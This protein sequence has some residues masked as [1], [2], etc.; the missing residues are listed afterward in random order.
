MR[1]LLIFFAGSTVGSVVTTVAIT[2]CMMAK[3]GD[4]QLVDGQ[5]QWRE[6][7]KRLLRE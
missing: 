5:Q 2:M 7:V 6:A 1:D 4:R 3:Q